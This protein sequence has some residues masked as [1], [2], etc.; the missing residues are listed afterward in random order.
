MGELMQKMSYAI[1]RV[2]VLS[3]IIDGLIYMPFELIRIKYFS[4]NW[5]VLLAHYILLGFYDVFFW[6]RYGATPGMMLLR[7]KLIVKEGTH[8][9][10]GRAILR[11]IGLYISSFTIIG[12]LWMLWD[13]RKQM[14]HDKIAGTYVIQKRR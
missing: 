13:E 14:W 10:L 1:F 6:M 5:K 11:H 7:I 9:T 3:G 8:F 12:A 2:R 4:H